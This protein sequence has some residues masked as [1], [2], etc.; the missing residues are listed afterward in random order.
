V[1]T[2]RSPKYREMVTVT[3]PLAPAVNPATGRETTPP[4]HVVPDVPARLSQRPVAEVGSQG[5][6]LAEQNTT[7]SAWTLLVP[8][9]TVLTERS[10]VLDAKGRT[11]EV[12][13][14]VADRPNDKPQFRAAA[15]RL[16]SDLQE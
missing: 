12:V 7:I 3:T 6:Q 2:S 13:G 15:L 11:F 16:I 5:E 1:P 10:T 4:P 8:P 9:D 14:K